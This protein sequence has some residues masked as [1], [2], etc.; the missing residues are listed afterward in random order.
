MVTFR[1][2][3]TGLSLAAAMDAAFATQRDAVIVSCGVRLA[4]QLSQQTR[5]LQPVHLA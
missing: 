2:A 1:L 5:L 3:D 4:V